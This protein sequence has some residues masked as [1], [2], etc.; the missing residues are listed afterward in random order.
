MV[1]L[2]SKIHFDI[3]GYL[4]YDVP[5]NALRKWD[6][7]ATIVVFKSNQH[8]ADRGFSSYTDKT[9]TIIQK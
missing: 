1:G 6:T 3:R 4:I 8:I 2:T 7:R 9:W 5:S